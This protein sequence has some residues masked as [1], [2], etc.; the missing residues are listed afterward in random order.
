M[1][2]TLL[3]IMGAF[4]NWNCILGKSKMKF[5]VTLSSGTI[6]HIKFVQ[7]NM[8][9][10]STSN[11]RK[12]SLYL[13]RNRQITYKSKQ[14]CRILSYKLTLWQTNCY[15]SSSIT[16]RSRV[17]FLARRL[18]M[19]SLILQPLKATVRYSR[20]D[21]MVAAVRMRPSM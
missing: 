6:F 15:Y 21:Q 20:D 11:Q 10:K 2:L 5:S 17:H 14:R 12:D 18:A 7:K 19:L 9:L 8:L 3:M 4:Y 13:K 16:E 1:H